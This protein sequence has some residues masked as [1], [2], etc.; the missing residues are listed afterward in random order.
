MRLAERPARGIVMPKDNLNTFKKTVLATAV[1]IVTMGGAATVIGKWAPWAWAGEFKVAARDSYSGLI[2]QQINLQII[3]REQIRKARKE[4]RTTDA[5]SLQQ[6][7][8][9]LNEHIQY[10]RSQQIRYLK[11]R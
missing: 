5:T 4:G 8:A 6:Q 11:R 1:L 9:Q 10:L 7:E 3:L 2:V